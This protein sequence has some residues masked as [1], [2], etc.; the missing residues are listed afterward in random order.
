MP[1]CE[2]AFAMWKVFQKNFF[3]DGDFHCPPQETPRW[4]V[5]VVVV[6]VVVRDENKSL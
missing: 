6:V 4:V 5:V 1:L 3:G 2:A